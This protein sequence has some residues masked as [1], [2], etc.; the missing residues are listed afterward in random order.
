MDANTENTVM[1]FFKAMADVERLK[2]TGLLA[3]SSHS[4]GEIANFLKIKLPRV[5]NHLGYLTHLGL[6]TQDGPTYSL[7]A[8]AVQVMARQVLAGSRP[9]VN[10]EELEGPEYDRKVLS[11]FLQPDGKIK[12]LPMQQKKLMVLLHYLLPNFQE[13]EKYPEKSV[14]DILG[15]Y[16]EDTATLRRSMVD[17]GLLQRKE[18][19]YWRTPGQVQAE[20][21]A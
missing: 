10:L 9:A 8:N 20:G 16:F 13:N 1:E 17:Q 7:D 19:V 4:A 14:N 6:V 18:G 21:A 5:V 2:I 3:L 11:A 15:R 12:A